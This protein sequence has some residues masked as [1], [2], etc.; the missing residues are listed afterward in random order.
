MNFRNIPQQLIPLAILFAAALAALIVARQLLVPDSFGEYSHYRADAVDEIASLD[1]SYAGSNAC[2]DC[3]DDIFEIKQES[4]HSGLTCE[5]CHGPAAEHVDAPDEFTPSAPRGRG[6][7]PLCHGYNPS[8]PSGFPQILAE[9]HNP[10]RACMTC[11]DP[12]NPVLPHA[13]EE[14]SACHR[15]IS[16][17]K[18]VSHHATLTCTT[19][20]VVPED[21]W[22]NPRF[23]RAEKP[24]TRELCGG[25]HSEDADSPREI[26]RIDLNA[27]GE[28][29]LCWDCHYPHHPEANQ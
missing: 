20:H 21:H 5:V 4:N 25:C 13:P 24:S 8:R 9:L 28:R 1:I 10:G 18:M 3:H 16:N 15:E 7:C 23:V 6:Y 2:F 22:I 17:Q 12:H 26:P 27:H 14:C 29:Y 11:H 19:C